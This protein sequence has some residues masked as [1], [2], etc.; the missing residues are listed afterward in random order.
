MLVNHSL[1]LSTKWRRISSCFFLSSIVT[2]WAKKINECLTNLPNYTQRF[3]RMNSI[4]LSLYLIESIFLS[5]YW[6]SKIIFI[7]FLFL[8]F[9]LFCLAKV[10]VSSKKNGK[11]ISIVEQTI[12]LSL[13]LSLLY[14]VRIV[15]TVSRSMRK[16][17]FPCDLFFSE[18]YSVFRVKMEKNKKTSS[19]TANVQLNG[20]DQEWVRRVAAMVLVVANNKATFCELDWQW[21]TICYIEYLLLKDKC[22]CF[23]CLSF[24]FARLKT[25]QK[26]KN[27]TS[28]HLWHVYMWF[29]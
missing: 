23:I 20:F 3:C 21:R 26:Q 11:S 14:S 10:D 4:D 29:R 7:T 2:K 28:K 25:K 17:G 1:S 24:A 27:E 5:A 18:E 15:H 6:I 19:E 9:I 12:R 13:S 16:W 22:K 8:S